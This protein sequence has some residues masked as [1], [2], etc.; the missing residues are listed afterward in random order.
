MKKNILLILL[1]LN[2]HSFSVFSGLNKETIIIDDAEK[3]PSQKSLNQI[4]HSLR[5]NIKF[6]EENP[7]FIKILALIAEDNLFDLI[8]TFR[9][10]DDFTK[11][12]N[13]LNLNA[14]NRDYYIKITYNILK[15]TQPSE[16]D[17]INLFTFITFIYENN[18]DEPQE[19]VSLIKKMI[20]QKNVNIKNNIIPL[21][22]IINNS[23]KKQKKELLSIQENILSII[24][25]KQIIESEYTKLINSINKKKLNNENLNGIIEY[26]QIIKNKKKSNINHNLLLKIILQTNEFEFKNA[27]PF[28]HKIFS[29]HSSWT[30]NDCLYISDYIID[31][32]TSSEFKERLHYAL[33]MLEKT[34][35][36]VSQYINFI[37]F[38]YDLN[39]NDFNNFLLHYDFNNFSLHIENILKTHP[40][41]IYN[42]F[43]ETHK[44]ILQKYTSPIFIKRLN[45]A[46]DIFTSLP[47]HNQW[48]SKNYINYIDTIC[49][50][51]E[52]SFK[53]LIHNFTIIKENIKNTREQDVFFEFLTKEERY[54][55]NKIEFIKNIISTNNN[56]IW[57][58][59]FKILTHEKFNKKNKIDFLNSI[60]SMNSLKEKQ[61]IISFIHKYDL[62]IEE[63]MNLCAALNEIEDKT[64][65]IKAYATLTEEYRQQYKKNLSIPTKQLVNSLSCFNPNDRISLAKKIKNLYTTPQAPINELIMILYFIPS[66][67]HNTYINNDINEFFIVNSNAHN[68]NSYKD[69]Y[70]ITLKNHYNDQSTY[71]KN[72]YHEHWIHILNNSNLNYSIFL[73]DFIIYTLEND[74]SEGIETN[75]FEF[76]QIIQNIIKSQ[77]NSYDN[78]ENLL[79][80]RKINT[81][82]FNNNLCKETYNN[83]IIFLN[84]TFFKTLSQKTSIDPN[85]VPYVSPSILI[86]MVSNIE[87]SM[88]NEEFKTEVFQLIGNEKE[89]NNWKENIIAYDSYLDTLLKTPVE[90]I[91]GAQFK[92]IMNYVLSLPKEAQSNKLSD[93]QEAFIKMIMTIFACPIG[94]DAGITNAYTSLPYESKLQTINTEEDDTHDCY[95]VKSL[96]Q[97]KTINFLYNVLQENVDQIFYRNDLLLFINQNDENLPQ[98]VHQ[99]LYLRNLIGDLV[100]SRYKIQF[101]LYFYEPNASPYFLNLTRQE[102]LNAFYKHAKPLDII[103]YTELKINEI[104]EKEFPKTIIPTI[105]Q[106][107][108]YNGI[109][110]I[111][112]EETLTT[113]KLQNIIQIITPQEIFNFDTD[114]RPISIK[115]DAVLKLLIKINAIHKEP[116]EVFMNN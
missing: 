97:Q 81:K 94:K 115:E 116:T 71:Y 68:N 37:D 27:I 5:L 11:K 112:I 15:K 69:T 9:L 44:Y 29:P 38:T 43:L 78:H 35:W 16:E 52:S 114:Y 86:N 55:H 88:K 83:N 49:N 21:I 13:Q 105:Q 103:K 79:K 110:D 87:H 1:T 22:E 66:E 67:L 53:K 111:L 61:E 113:E 30:Y 75:V 63:T 91:I 77:N 26:L 18:Y 82:I 58:Q 51:N 84:P 17:Y 6:Y 56:K 23:D 32:I 80:K 4:K 40:E 73:T 14:E 109:I 108:I 10:T 8:K 19:I 34:N 106:R 62:G 20:H 89:F 42:N 95:Y 104:L 28:F 39:Q 101:D 72:K 65:L 76:A 93:Q 24:P 99:S 57:Y 33:S 50:L 3:T 96:A 48:N 98:P 12:L 45:T 74:F 85:S 64:H 31:R 25:S 46:Q 100:G 107:P 90:H 70:H 36:C 60:F 7:N 2:L 92:C 41:W 54:I 59:A 47:I 102:A